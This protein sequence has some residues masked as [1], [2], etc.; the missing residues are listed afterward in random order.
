MNR[1]CHQGCFGTMGK[2]KVSPGDGGESTSVDGSGSGSAVSTPE[3]AVAESPARLS[4]ATT[5]RAAKKQRLSYDERLERIADAAR[6]IIECLDDDPSREGLVKTPYRFAKALLDL[7][8]GYKASPL[9]AVGDAEFREDHSEMVLLRNI[10]IF[11]TC[12]HHLLPFYGHCHIAY[13]PNGT[14]VGLSKIARIIDIFSH[15]LQ[16]QERLTT[17]IADAILHATRARGVM[18]YL[19]CSHMCMA[20]R[21][22][23]KSDV[24]TV[25]TAARGCYKDDAT[26]RREFF[27]IVNSSLN[28][29]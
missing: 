14:V 11:S 27:A 23:R 5:A 4:P 24:A 7:T 19:S 17:Q 9:A 16:V 26:L 1:A 13:I 20:M 2:R 12:E 25:T 10:E 22:V 21:G 8:N 29:S 28:V 3:L 18:V 6:T 15:R